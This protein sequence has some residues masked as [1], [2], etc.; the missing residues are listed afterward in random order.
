M[1][2]EQTSVASQGAVDSATKLYSTMR[3]KFPAAVEEFE[4][5]WTVVRAACNSKSITTTTTED[6]ACTRTQEFGAL[7]RLGPK[8]IPLVVFKLATDS[9]HQDSWAVF[10]Y[11]ALEDDP[12][13]LPSRRVDESLRRCIREITEL[14]YQRNN[15]AEERVEA[16]KE[17]HRKDP[18]SSSHRAFTMCDEYFDLLEMGPSIIAHIMVA[19]YDN[20]MGEWFHLLHEMIDGH[21]FFAH[22]YCPGEIFQAWCCW[23]NYGEYN[24]SPKYVP[25]KADRYIF[26]LDQ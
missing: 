4:S 5:R 20:F 23:F 24:Q 18:F 26:G 13:Y 3:E 6:D 17:V 8:I 19:Y 16:W 14:N 1:E 11:N 2:A 7:Q 25:T 15:M 12:N 9:N 22:A 21:K 10:L